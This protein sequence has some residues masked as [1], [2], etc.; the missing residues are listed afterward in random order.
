M[1]KFIVELTEN[2]REELKALITKGK[3]SSELNKKARI[4]L[5]ADQSGGREYLTDKEIALAIETSIP[6]VERL[7]KRF[8]QEGYQECLKRRARTD[9]HPNFKIDGEVEA[10]IT[11]LATSK[12]PKGRSRWTLQLLA[13]QMVEL[14]YIDTISDESVRKVLKKTNLSRGQKRTGVS[15]LETL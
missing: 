3:T 7:R 14:K 6:T 11:A 4:L 15:K 1:K 5:K 2:E 13:D 10:H 9:V 12:P 8:V